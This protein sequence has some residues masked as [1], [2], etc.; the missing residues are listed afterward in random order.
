MSKPPRLTRI[1]KIMVGST[2]HMDVHLF[3]VCELLVYASEGDDDGDD[4]DDH[5]RSNPAYPSEG[6]TKAWHSPTSPSTIAVAVCMKN[7]C[8][9]KIQ[10]AAGIR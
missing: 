6:D 4:D 10:M 5:D 1:D 8:S 7:S 2:V 3:C 9:A